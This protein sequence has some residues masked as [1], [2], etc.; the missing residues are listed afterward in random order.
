MVGNGSAHHALDPVRGVPEG[1]P[2]DPVAVDDRADRH[3]L[4]Q[5]LQPPAP[6]SAAASAAA[7]PPRPPPTTS[8]VARS[9]SIRRGFSSAAGRA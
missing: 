9:S 7:T 8:T 3:V 2:I 4:E 1:H 6:R 5:D